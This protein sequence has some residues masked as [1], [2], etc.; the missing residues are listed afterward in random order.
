MLGE[1]IIK[2][3]APPVPLLLM[4]ISPL[5]STFKYWELT[6]TFPAVHAFIAAF[7]K[8]LLK[9]LPKMV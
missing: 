8:L 4:A 6:V 9:L 2:L 3:P 7:N 5:F 1:L